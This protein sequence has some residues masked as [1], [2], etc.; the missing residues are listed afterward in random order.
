[1]SATRSNAPPINHSRPPTSG[2]RPDSSTSFQGLRGSSDE[3]PIASS[4]IDDRDNLNSD[5]L[6][7]SF[8][9]HRSRSSATEIP[10]NERIQQRPRTSQKRPSDQDEDELANEDL[11][12]ILPS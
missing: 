7:W 6:D 11:F 9:G 3:P 10:Y 12:S 2:F 4:T 1:M 5:D 8:N